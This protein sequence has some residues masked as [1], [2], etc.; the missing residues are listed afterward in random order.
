[1]RKRK[2]K[3]DDMFS[4]LD[5]FFDGRYSPEEVVI[6]SYDL[7]DGKTVKRI[8]YPFEYGDVKCIIEWPSTDD[9]P[10]LKT[11]DLLDNEVMA[12]LGAR[13]KGYL[14]VDNWIVK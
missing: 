1:M 5:Y 11:S 14:G 10:T 3:I 9:E 7:P 8:S 2:L 4:F 12:E 6:D 13:L